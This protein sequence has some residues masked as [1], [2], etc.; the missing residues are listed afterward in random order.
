MS[1]IIF[2]IRRTL[3]NLFQRQKV[4]SDHNVA[5]L[6]QFTIDEKKIA[7]C[8]TTFFFHA[9]RGTMKIPEVVKIAV[10]QEANRI[11]AF[12]APV[13]GTI[14]KNARVLNATISSMQKELFKEELELE[15]IPRYMTPD[16]VANYMPWTTHHKVLAAL[17]ITGAVFCFLLSIWNLNLFITK[18]Y[19]ILRG[20][21]EFLWFFCASFPLT[22]AILIESVG[23]LDRWIRISA[24]TIKWI[25]LRALLGLPIAMMVLYGMSIAFPVFGI[26]DHNATSGASLTF[27]VLSIEAIAG[28]ICWSG[29][30]HLIKLHSVPNNAKETPR[31]IEQR[32]RV[33]SRRHGLAET[34]QE[35]EAS[36]A[37]LEAINKIRDS[38]LNDA[39]I[40]A[41]M[42]LET[43]IFMRGGF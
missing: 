30:L 25:V 4:Y 28:S 10:R 8:V 32:A 2:F 5:P 27:L 7:A 6:P 35:Y 36:I 33:E 1:R 9:L 14:T 43:I 15:H 42:H 17:G 39:A 40:Y 41:A 34:I 37:M 12:I 24:W 23:F 29:V 31:Y 22:T 3:A 18:H 21:T 16:G 19:S 11:D 13:V 20:Q 26:G 38:H